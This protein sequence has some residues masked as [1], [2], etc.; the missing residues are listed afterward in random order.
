M[1]PRLVYSTRVS[2]SPEERGE[3]IREGRDQL[4]IVTMQLRELAQRFPSSIA[5][6]LQMALNS[7]A[8]FPRKWCTRYKAFQNSSS[9]SKYWFTL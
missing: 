9:A 3:I 1:R 2:K 7:L 8:I 6:T 4:Q 5:A